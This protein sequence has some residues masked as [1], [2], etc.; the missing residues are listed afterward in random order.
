MTLTAEA[1]QQIYP[2]HPIRF[3]ERVDSTNDLAL[4]WL[5]QGTAAGSVIVA[6]EQMQ[7]RGRLGRTW[8]TPPGVALAV[9]VILRP[10]AAQ[11][12]QVTMLGALAIY[13]VLADFGVSQLG[14]KWPN[15]VQVNGRKI[16]GILPEAAWSGEQ[17]VGVVLGLGLNV[18]VNFTGTELAETA[19]SLETVLGQS[20][21]RL[22][23]LA[24]LLANINDW[25]AALG[26]AWLF[27][28]WK[29]RLTTL[30]QPVTVGEIQGLAE[31][32][33]AE[34]ALLVRDASDV[35]HRVLA[36]DVALG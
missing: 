17:L 35:V 16:S 25:A 21:S 4:E 2:Q 13:D 12:P 8:H 22:D 24:R 5:W 15:D 30:G 26:E 20:V 23:V 28:T 36:G 19:T 31:Q 33:N 14:I 9:S 27:E 6:D 10:A 11:L 18:R 7:G 29:S 1:I 32:V 3:Y 34:G